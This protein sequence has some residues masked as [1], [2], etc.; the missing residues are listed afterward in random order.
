MADSY[1]CTSALMTCTFG[2]A[3]CPL[4]VN[5]SRTVM[6]QGKQR[7]NIGDFVPMTN[8]ASFGMCSAPTNPT[9]I[10]ATAAAM[11]V[12]TPMPCVPAIVSPWI[13]G[14]PDMLVQGMP[15]LTK[16]SRNVCMWLGQISFTN[17]GQI[18]TPPPL[19]T[20]PPGKMRCIPTGMRRPLTSQELSNLS[21]DAKEQYKNDM[22]KAKNAGI[23]NEILASTWDKV[24]DDYEQKGEIEKAERARQ[25]AEKEHNAAADKKNIAIG[26]V[27]QKYRETMPP[28][29]DN[30]ALLSESDRIEYEQK[31]NAIKKEQA[32]AYKEAG[33]DRQLYDN[34]AHE[35][36]APGNYSSGSEMTAA[37][38]GSLLTAITGYIME[39]HAKDKADEK[40]YED[41]K[42]L[43]Q[44][45][46]KKI[47]QQNECCPN[48][49]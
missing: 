23:Q 45:T 24:A 29:K 43:N 19:T 11:G 35:M 32:D 12:F 8:I 42:Q 38:G 7:A 13:P 5:P 49:L 30:L 40:A 34:V 28:S 15:A 31:S 36:A 6:L 37:K 25:N 9:V 21:E 1:V 22:A 39:G 48:E 2:V 27:N 46:N 20:P 4:V 41:M 16:S 47:Q 14:K 33:I 18:P 44:K 3:P 10:A 26:N 17:E